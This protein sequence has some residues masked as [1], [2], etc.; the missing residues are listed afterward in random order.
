VNSEVFAAGSLRRAVGLVWDQP[1]DEPESTKAHD[2]GIAAQ[3]PL[4]ANERSGKMEA[5]S[6]LNIG[7]LYVLSLFGVNVTALTIYHVFGA[8]GVFHAGSRCVGVRHSGDLRDCAVRPDN[9]I[10]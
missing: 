3:Q 4:E 10:S 8:F 1:G 2:H 7:V 9:R 6:Q 5:R